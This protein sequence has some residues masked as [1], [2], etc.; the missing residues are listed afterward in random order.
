MARPDQTPRLTGASTFTPT[1]STPT[2]SPSPTPNAGGAGPGPLLFGP[3]EVHVQPV[4]VQLP[5]E[6]LHV[7][8]SGVPEKI[9]LAWEA[10]SV[11]LNLHWPKDPL[12]ISIDLKNG[13][14]GPRE[15]EFQKVIDTF[16]QL[17]RECKEQLSDLNKK[18]A[19][20]ERQSKQ[21]QKTIDS[22]NEQN[23]KCKEQ[24]TD[25]NNKLTNTRD[26]LAKER[27]EYRK[28]LDRLLKTGA[29]SKEEFEKKMKEFEGG[30]RD[31]RPSHSIIVIGIIISG[32]LGG[33]AAYNI[34]LVRQRWDQKR[35]AK[36]SKTDAAA[37]TTSFGRPTTATRQ[38]RVDDLLAAV[39][40]GV[41]AAFMVP[42]LLHILSIVTHQ[43]ISENQIPLE[44]LWSLCFVG[45]TLGEP[46]IES[47]SSGFL[48][49]V[50]AFFEWAVLKADNWV[51]KTASK[52]SRKDGD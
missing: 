40:L 24:V 45:A 19:D 17:N 3:I 14:V 11:P 36:A 26:Q 43:A 16:S 31:D 30:P 44:Y 10:K 49:L 21:L 15:S 35:K 27:E 12:N 52:V 1:P 7:T 33:A 22:S 50:N 6:D 46:F 13:A 5:K 28:E 29:L 42:G 34:T 20:A 41:V 32:M 18:L 39:F 51:V 47:V 37:T 25:L 23:E 8:A 4:E 48:R 9:T 38:E 2:P